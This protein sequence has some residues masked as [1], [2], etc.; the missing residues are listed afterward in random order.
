ML[1]VLLALCS[2][3][4]SQ[5]EEPKTEPAK[6][7]SPKPAAPAPGKLEIQVIETHKD[8]NIR[9]EKFGEH[10]RRYL[11]QVG[12]DSS[13]RPA[14]ELRV[15][16]PPKGEN[17][18]AAFIAI[19]PLQTHLPSGLRFKVDRGRARTHSYTYAMREG[20]FVISGFS[21]TELQE[22]KRG[23]KLS[24]TYVL[25]SKPDQPIE[26]EFSLAGFTAAFKGL[27]AKKSP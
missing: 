25:I 12:K 26:V 9:E 17:V 1:L 18:S 3:A 22:L 21:S 2:P 15:T 7:E 10:V 14:A 5:E 20:T 19:T 16:L 6:P 24:M 11:H 23:A 13:G 8:W 27:E 4:Y